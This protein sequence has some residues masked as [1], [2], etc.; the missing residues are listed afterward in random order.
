M[1]CYFNILSLN[2]TWQAEFWFDTFK[3]ANYGFW[4]LNLRLN[5]SPKPQ[6]RYMQGW[7]QKYKI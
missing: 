1:T 6:I 5:I 4:W 2:A 3:S 7:R